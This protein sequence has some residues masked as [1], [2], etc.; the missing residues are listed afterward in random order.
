MVIKKTP[1][2]LG[3]DELQFQVR[4]ILLLGAGKDQWE[5]ESKSIY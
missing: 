4:Y 5:Y 2:L 1:L 3:F